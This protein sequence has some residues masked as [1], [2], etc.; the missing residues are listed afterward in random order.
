VPLLV[1]VNDVD[2][3]PYVEAVSIDAVGNERSTATIVLEGDAGAPDED[4]PV[5]IYAAD[6]V[7]VQF[8]GFVRAVNVRGW[9]DHTDA[10]LLDVEVDGWERVCDWCSISLSYT[11]PVDLEDVW[12]DIVIGA[13]AAYGITYTPAATGVTLDP[14]TVTDMPVVDL[15]RELRGR[16]N[17]LITFLPDKSTTITAWGATSAPQTLTGTTRKRWERV[18]RGTQSRD[19]A[20]IVKGLFG[21]TGQFPTTKQWATNGSASSFE[22]DIQAAIGGWTQGYV[23]ELDTNGDLVADRTVS[24]PGAGGYYEWDDTDGRGRLSVAAGSPP[25]AGYLVWVYTGVFPFAVEAGSGSPPREYRFRNEKIDQYGPATEFVAAVLARVDRPSAR[26]I[27]GTTLYG[28]GWAPGQALTVNLSQRA[29]PSATYLI[30]S[31]NATCVKDELWRYTITATEGSEPQRTLGDELRALFGGASSG[32]GGTSVLNIAAGSGGG[33]GASVPWAYL[34]GARSTSET[35]AA[36]GTYEPVPQSVEFVSPVTYSGRVRVQL[37][38]AD[39][40]V[41]VTAR[42][43]NLTDSTTAGTSAAVENTS[44]E[45]TTF[46]VSVVAGK[47][48]RLEVTADTNGARVYATGTLEALS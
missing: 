33:T 43:R 27:T 2:V 48:Y 29:A 24:G 39:S 47:R 16:T 44:F 26:L 13:L 1:E 14:F 21:P 12:E 10:A 23:R 45:E 19:R 30:Q 8:G 31:V 5:K 22:V 9:A 25:A 37:R 38:A 41:E 42:L 40:G 46:V 11:A 32:G 28:T 3:T 35:I 17:R 15:V 7:T 18:D 20:N 34:G 6:G 4:D 36:A